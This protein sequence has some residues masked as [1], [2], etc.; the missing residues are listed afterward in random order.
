MRATRVI[1]THDPAATPVAGATAPEPSHATRP[2][3]AT[4]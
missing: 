4:H 3:D 1:A 2:D